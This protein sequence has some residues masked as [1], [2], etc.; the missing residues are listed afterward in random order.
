VLFR[1][2]SRA[3]ENNLLTGSRKMLASYIA[4]FAGL[5]VALSIGLLAQTPAAHDGGALKKK[6]T[7]EDELPRFTYQLPNRSVIQ[8][9]KSDTEWSRFAAHVRADL[10]HVLAE[11]DIEDKSTL[12][13]IHITL[14]QLDVM[15]GREEE[16]RRELA[17]LP[18]LEDKPVL[19]LVGGLEYEAFLDARREAAGDLTRLRQS[20]RQHLESRLAALPWKIAGD[21]AKES[22]GNFQS[23]T[24]TTILETAA[25]QWEKVEKTGTISNDVARY[26]I[27]TR[28]HWTELR[29]L[30]DENEH[31][32]S[33]YIAAH[34]TVKPDIW[35]ERSV[36]L[37]PDQKLTPVVIGIWD[38]GVDTSLFP[39]QW[40][41]TKGA[42]GIGFDLQ[43]RPVSGLLYPVPPDELPH[44]PEA[45]K[46][47]KGMLDTYMAIDSAEAAS[48]RKQISALRQDEVREFNDRLNLF[49][50]YVH[51][52]H[53]AGI[54]VEGNP[55][56]RL[57]VGVVSGP[58][59]TIPD[60]ITAEQ[61]QRVADS[62]QET[63]KFFRANHT[64]MVN[65]SWYTS[66]KVYEWILEV[67]GVGKDATERAQRA[68][69]L[70]EI[71]KVG[72]SSAITAS[73]DILF[74]CGAGNTNS[75]SNFGEFI[76]GS[77]Q[78]PNVLTVGAVD[79]AGEATSFTS[80]GPDV[81]VYANGFEVLSWVPGGERIK[82]SGTSIAA[83]NVTNLAAKLLAVDPS[84][85]PPEIVTL[86]K[87]GCHESGDGRLHLIDPKRTMELLEERQRR[88]AK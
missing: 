54:A 19:K 53:V 78:F 20:Y 10:E 6:I 45:R 18:K 23:F 5:F 31:V 50:T 22:K 47:L 7:K 9:L 12:A 21:Y 57:L 60:P 43:G 17:L 46:L 30:R 69:Q 28:W 75:D 79:Q 85:T 87:Q 25:A 83:P 73:P 14:L 71:S 72:L 67:N 36:T 39:G 81:A 64:R 82:L 24:D 52:T 16:A 51:G 77:F 2:A 74:I 88:A 34:Q 13:G 70:F 3:I 56:A 41:Q 35:A 86:I 33:S 27:S 76:P 66:P 63:T 42:P 58:Y 26:L 37:K 65:I 49:V 8:L 44:Y 40:A 68:R 59:K 32:Y 62:L 1:P 15:A 84:L 80:F 38:S 29:L 61:I 48:Y 4:K 55:F 11:Y